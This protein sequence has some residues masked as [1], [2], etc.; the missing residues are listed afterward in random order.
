MLDLLL[1]FCTNQLL[2]WLEVMSLLGELEGAI[3]ALQSAERIVNV[4]DVHPVLCGINYKQCW[5][6]KNVEPQQIEIVS[7]LG[8]C[9]RMTQEYHPT[10]SMAPLQLHHYVVPFLPL[11]CR[12]SQV[13]GPKLHPGIEVKEG[14]EQTWSPCVCVL[15]DILAMFGVLPFLQMDNSWCLVPMIPLSGYGTCLLGQFYKS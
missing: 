7:L 15:E 3:A 11:Q 13:Y 6:D 1:N 14:Y 10:I 12:L 8:D 2:N 9:A 5:F 4:S